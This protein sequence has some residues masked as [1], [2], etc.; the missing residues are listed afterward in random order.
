VGDT[1]TTSSGGAAQPSP[2]LGLLSLYCDNDDD[3]GV[4]AKVDPTSGDNGTAQTY[5]VGTYNFGTAMA[6]ESIS[7]AADAGANVI[8][9]VEDN[10]NWLGDTGT[11]TTFNFWTIIRGG[12]GED[13]SLIVINADTG[14][15]DISDLI[16]VEGVKITSAGSPFNGIDELW[17]HDCEFDTS[18]TALVSH[19]GSP[20][21]WHVTHCTLTQFAQGLR[22]FGAS[23]DNP[24]GVVRGNTLAGFDALIQV[25]V[26]V[27]NLKNTVYDSSAQLF[28]DILT[29]AATPS[30][31]RLL[32][33]N[34]ILGYDPSGANI[35]FEF[36]G[37]DG[38]N[39][40]K[41]CVVGNVLEMIDSG[42]SLGNLGPSDSDN[43]DWIVWNNTFL[44]GRMQTAYNDDHIAEKYYWSICN[45]YW[46]VRGF[47]SDVFGTNGTYIENWQVMYQVGCSSNIDA[48][49]ATIAAQG[50]DAYYSGLRSQE[51]VDE[52]HTWPDFVNA[53]R[54]TGSAGVGLGDYHVNSSSPLRFKAK[55]LLPHDIEGK[56]RF[57]GDPVGAYTWLN[58][59]EHPPKLRKLLVR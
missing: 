35:M 10:Y 39:Y 29:G 57:S 6:Y 31:P 9:L 49:I 1:T 4:F 19:A 14:D 38:E 45:T 58:D 59:Q 51:P 22:P 32:S 47:K 20:G 33:D 23:Q 27:G 53:A 16:K 52:L 44:G 41:L 17:F 24:P 42:N 18:A 36:A 15:D 46:D 37:S 21:V 2:L 56:R 5:T 11:Y 54:Y 26:C 43:H 34:L 48:G 3:A 8:E 25:Y 30:G 50:F 13:E 12:P 28:D 40:D 55:L 7:A